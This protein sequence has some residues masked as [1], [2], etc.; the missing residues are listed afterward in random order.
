MGDKIIEFVYHDSL[1]KRPKNLQNNVFVLYSPKRIKLRKREIMNVNKK[2]SV[3]MPEQ[4][5]AACV[6]LPILCKNGLSMKSFQY[7][8]ANSNICNAYQPINLPWK[9]HFEL[10][11]RSTNSI[12]STCKRQSL[13]FL[14]T[15][16]DE[17][18][19]LKVKHAKT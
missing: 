8:S 18:K 13:S 1:Q 7:I 11:N 14:T 5:I 16:N 6:I 4:I 17:V 10:V 12:F 3:H 15:L 9:V 2:L 19:E